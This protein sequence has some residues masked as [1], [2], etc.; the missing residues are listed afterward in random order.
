MAQ[1]V[2]MFSQATH[3]VG[4]IGGG[5][6]NLV[7]AK[8]SCKVVCIGSPEFERINHRFLFT[9]NHTDLTMFRDTQTAS[10]L[11][12][13]AKFGTF[14]GEVVADE[15]ETLA[16]A[17]GNGV[18]WVDGEGDIRVVPTRDVTFLDE[19]LNSPWTFSVSECMKFIQ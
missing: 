4:A 3:V 8:P 10:L 5:M 9:M 16:L 14:L 17:L 6:C 12:R 13:R 18:T 1:K 7:F 11:Y 2:Q 15:G 19:G